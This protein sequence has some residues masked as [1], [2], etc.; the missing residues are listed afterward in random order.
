VVAAADG[1]LEFSHQLLGLFVG[2]P[3]AADPVEVNL[4]LASFTDGFAT[5]TKSATS[6]EFTVLEE[7]GEAEHEGIDGHFGKFPFV[8][9]RDADTVVDRLER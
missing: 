9:L 3:L 2:E 1:A 7:S 5:L 8:G 4:G 6:K